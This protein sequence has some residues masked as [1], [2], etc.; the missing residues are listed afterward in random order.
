MGNFL[1]SFSAEV[2]PLID[3]IL[4]KEKILK[5]YA[6]IATMQ[7]IRGLLDAVLVVTFSYSKDPITDN[8]PELPSNIQR[9]GEEIKGYLRNFNGRL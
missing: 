5:K 1:K 6:C 3:D 4:E 9:V 7:T 8:S 2:K